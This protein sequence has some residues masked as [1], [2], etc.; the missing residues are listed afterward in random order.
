MQY[1]HG[2]GPELVLAWREA[3]ARGDVDAMLSVARFAA[4]T[5]DGFDEAERMLRSA[6]GHGN[7]EAIHRLGVMLWRRGETGEGEGLIRRAA[8]GGFQDAIATMGNL[9]EQHGDFDGATAWYTKVTG[10]Q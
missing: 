5:P 7:V 9:C 6:V 4:R 8:L 2:E 1:R 10:D 3:A